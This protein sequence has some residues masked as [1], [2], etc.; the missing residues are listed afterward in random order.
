V[1]EEPEAKAK[2]SKPTAKPTAKPAA[3]AAEPPKKKTR[4]K[5]EVVEAPAKSPFMDD[6]DDVKKVELIKEEDVARCPS[7]AKE[8]EHAEAKVCLH[9][10]F[11]NLTRERAE[12]V[13]VDEATGSDWAMHL[14][15]AIIAIVITLVLLGI[16]IWFCSNVREW[17]VGSIVDK[18]EKDAAGRPTFYVHPAAFMFAIGIISARL[19]WTCSRF[20]FQR[21]VYDLKPQEKVRK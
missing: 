3:K 19:A 1:A 16:N 2:P 11:N 12:T 6:D 18:E 10:G 17:M 9:C 5:A 20:A 14:L 8:L 13:I 15:P 21:L 4:I 7:C